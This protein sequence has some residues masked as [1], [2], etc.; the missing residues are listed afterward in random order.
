MSDK[1]IEFLGYIAA[2]LTTISFAPQ[3]F[4][5]WRN[6]PTPATAISLPMYV[7]LIL[8]IIGWLR[9][10]FLIHSQP[11]YIANGVTLALALSILIYKIKYG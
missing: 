4:S 5:L 2:T 11:I 3:A 7:V 9:Y 10:G 1:K 6:R 8:G